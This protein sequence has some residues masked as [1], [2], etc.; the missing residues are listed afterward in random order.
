AAR[1]IIYIDEIDKL[2]RRTGHDRDVSGEGVQQGLL[3]ILEGKRVSVRMGVDR[4]GLGADPIEVDTSDVLFIAGGAFDGLSRQIAERR[5]AA[6]GFRLPG[7]ETAAREDQ[8]CH[9][10]P[11]DL[12]KFGMLPEFVGRFP[13]VVSLEALTESSLVEILT[14][15]KDAL[16]RQY[17]RLFA[18]E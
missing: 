4:S 9:V 7:G 13:I 11:Q 12:H 3:K 5:R 15:P 10:M 14:R 1:G 18:M 8:L 16:V 17:Q 2:A 6:S